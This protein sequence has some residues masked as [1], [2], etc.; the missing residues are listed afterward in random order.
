M[1]LINTDGMAFIGPGSEWFWTALSGIILAVTF[2]A[3]YRQ[4]KLQRSQAAIDQVDAFEREWATER[5]CRI[6]LNALIAYRDASNPAD[7]DIVSIGLI[8]IYWEKVASLVRRGHIDPQ[9]LWHISGFNCVAW[10]LILGPAI[11]RGR[12]DEHDPTTSADFEW[13]AG[14]MAE[15]DRRAGVPTY[16]EEGVAADIGTRIALNVEALRIEEALRT[17][18]VA[19]PKV[20]PAAAVPPP[21][22]AAAEG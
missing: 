20:E 10:W 13:L 15:L 11:R 14:T 6:R 4:L 22:S 2:I 9:L 1:K 17:T 16:T 3:I 21:T 7:L 8:A 18:I 12:A 19:S 5:M